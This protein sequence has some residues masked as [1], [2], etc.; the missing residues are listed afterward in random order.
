V[1]PR[2]KES[3]AGRDCLRVAEERILLEAWTE[4]GMLEAWRAEQ[5]QQV[6]AA[7]AKVQREPGPDPFEES[8]LTLATGHLAEGNSSNQGA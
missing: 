8:W 1:D 3:A 6:E 4:Q 5:V 2:V 7:V